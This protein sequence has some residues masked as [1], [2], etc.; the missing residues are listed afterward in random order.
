MRRP[1]P[2]AASSHSPRAA[3]RLKL[4]SNPEEKAFD[5]YLASCAISEKARAH[6]DAPGFSQVIRDRPLASQSP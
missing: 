4:V 6:G 3:Y 2:P 5:E 1:N